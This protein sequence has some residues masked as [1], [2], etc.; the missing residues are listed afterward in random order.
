MN[1]HRGFTLIELLLVMVLGMM[2]VGGVY[3]TMIRQEDAYTEL[4]ASAAAQQDVRGAMSLLTTELREISAEDGDLV[5]AGEG[6]LAIRALRHFGIVCGMDK[7]IKTLIV[8]RVGADEVNGF[9]SGDSITVFVDNDPMV[10]LDDV[11]QREKVSSVG[12][13]GDCSGPSLLPS[14]LSGLFSDPGLLRSL[15]VEG[16]GLMFENIHIGA[17]LRSFEHVTYRVGDWNGEAMLQRVVEDET[18]EEEV[19]QVVG[20]LAD[21]GGLVIAYYDTLGNALTPL[22]LSEPQRQSVGRV[23][24]TIRAERPTGGSTGRTETLT[25]DIYLRGN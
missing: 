21:P 3:G 1:N 24:L 4:T 10:G 16:N 12:S 6:S 14:P 13:P 15:S 22:P 9:E 5:I 25:S 17:P 2:V 8:S 11:W 19:I 18:G 20:P 23:Q 7:H